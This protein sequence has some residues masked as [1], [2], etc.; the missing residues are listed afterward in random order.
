MSLHYRLTPGRETVPIVQEDGWAPAPICKG[1]EIT[2][3]PGFEPRAVQLVASRYTNYAY[4]ALIVTCIN[5][6]YRKIKF[7]K[8]G[9]LEH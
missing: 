8:A 1:A 3:S 7:P 2:P 6:E 5:N 4:P 9:H